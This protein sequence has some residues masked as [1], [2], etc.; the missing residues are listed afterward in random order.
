MIYKFNFNYNEIF[1]KFIIESILERDIMV[2]YVDV[3]LIS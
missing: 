1:F 2:I 3:L